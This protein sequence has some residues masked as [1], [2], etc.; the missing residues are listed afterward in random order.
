MADSNTKEQLVWE[1]VTSNIPMASFR[2]LR[3]RVPGGWLVVVEDVN[4]PDVPKPAGCTFIPDPDP[5]RDMKV[6]NWL[7]G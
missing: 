6:G 5:E 1:E 4:R 3:A 2:T 7:T